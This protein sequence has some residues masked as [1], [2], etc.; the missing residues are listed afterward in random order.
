MNEVS[1][2]LVVSGDYNYL[3]EHLSDE[4]KDG[5]LTYIDGKVVVSDEFD[6]AMNNNMEVCEGKNLFF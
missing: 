6:E 2:R 5:N 4:S 3:V 1:Q